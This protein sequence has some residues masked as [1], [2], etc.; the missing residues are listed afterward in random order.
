MHWPMR[1]RI[2]S[3]TMRKD[4]RL[5]LIGTFAGL[6]LGVLVMLRIQRREQS[7]RSTSAA[8]ATN[9]HGKTPLKESG[10]PP[11]NLP[12]KIR[13]GNVTNRTD[14][15]ARLPDDV[16]AIHITPAYS[17]TFSA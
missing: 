7:V 1:H 16:A 4:L 11:P 12:G 6:V 14:S 10:M 13:D 5:L 9:H 8:V 2:P 17:I 3:R 15:V